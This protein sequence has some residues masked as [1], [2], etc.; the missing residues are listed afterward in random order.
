MSKATSELDVPNI[1]TS[2]KLLWANHIRE[3]ELEMLK[4]YTRLQALFKLKIAKARALLHGGPDL[5]EVNRAAKGPS[6]V[7]VGV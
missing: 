7:S 2:A 4:K 3:M 6:G 1:G 5:D